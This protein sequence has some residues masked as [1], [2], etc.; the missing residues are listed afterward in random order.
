M[1]ASGRKHSRLSGARDFFETKQVSIEIGRSLKIGHI[2][3]D[4]AEFFD[5]YAHTNGIIK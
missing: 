4:M 1:G 3:N 2:E 5:G